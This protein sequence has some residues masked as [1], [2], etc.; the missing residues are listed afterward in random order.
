MSCKFVLNLI[1]SATIIASASWLSDRSPR[2]AA[3]PI[4]TMILL[5]FSYYQHDNLQNTVILAKSI[6]IAVPVGLLFL[7]PFFSGEV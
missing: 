2:M 7:V 4:A 1:I 3:F 6:F 5:P